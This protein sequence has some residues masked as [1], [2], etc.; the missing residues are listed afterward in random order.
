[1]PEHDSEFSLPPANPKLRVD[2]DLRG[3]ELSILI[4]RIEQQ[5]WISSIGRNIRAWILSWTFPPGLPM[6]GASSRDDRS[7]ICDPTGMQVEVEVP[8]VEW[9]RGIFT[10]HPIPSPVLG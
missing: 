3:T 2:L 6:S 5:A 8:S 10:V 1:M 4:R 7:E 9:A